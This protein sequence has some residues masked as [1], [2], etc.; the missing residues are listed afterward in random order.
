KDLEI[1]GVGDILGKKQHGHVQ[2][3]GL[4]LYT[5]LLHQAVLQLQNQ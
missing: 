3:I 2:H 4:N 5:R 1:R